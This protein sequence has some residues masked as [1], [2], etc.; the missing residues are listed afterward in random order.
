MQLLYTSARRADGWLIEALRQMGHAVEIGEWAPEIAALAAEGGYDLVLADM[1]RPDP[2]TVAGL[3]GA[4]PLVLVA[5]VADAAERS[6][7]LRA[8]AEDCL[9]RPL[10]LMEVQ[11][12]LLAL[13]R[14]ADRLRA[15][16]EAPRQGLSFDRATHRLGLDGREAGLT[17][18]EFRLVAYLWR[19][20][21]EVVDLATLDRHLSGEAPE[22]QPERIRRLISRLRA[23][24]VRELGAP[25]VHSVRGHGYVLRLESPD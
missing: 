12:R 6:A 4:A 20:A 1:E 19:R 16:A 22:P 24:L 5:D 8:G 17:P 11:M 15:A 3:A 13:A 2:P 7:A 10:H 14:H 9:V 18:V 23:K 21:G 25:L